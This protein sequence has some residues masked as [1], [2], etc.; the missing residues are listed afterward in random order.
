MADSSLLVGYV[1]FFR[2]AKCD[3]LKGPFLT[4]ASDPQ[5]GSKWHTLATVQLEEEVGRMAYDRWEEHLCI[6]EAGFS[7]FEIAYC[8]EKD[9]RLEST[10]RL[11]LLVTAGWFET[12]DL[13]R[14][15]PELVRAFI[16]GRSG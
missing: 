12:L 11:R 3:V 6:R 2:A 4:G 5:R 15:A 16:H 10:G 14:D 13:L 7:E 1:A 9:G 8:V